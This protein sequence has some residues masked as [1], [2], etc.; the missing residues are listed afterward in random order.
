VGSQSSKQRT[1]QKLSASA[2][3]RPRA[4]AFLKASTDRALER[5]LPGGRVNQTLSQSRE[6]EE[7]HMIF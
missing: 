7:I 4:P 5:Q 1:P 6:H 3:M 2:R